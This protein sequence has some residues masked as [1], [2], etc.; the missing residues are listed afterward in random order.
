L[1]SAQ[2]FIVRIKV[3]PHTADLYL[4]YNVNFIIK[5]IYITADI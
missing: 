5:V 1:Q 4:T 3:S 2:L